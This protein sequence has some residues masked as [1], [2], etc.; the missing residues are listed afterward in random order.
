[1][2]IQIETECT[3]LNV[4]KTEDPPGTVGREIPREP[5]LG[6]NQGGLCWGWMFQTEPGGEREPLR[7]GWGV[8]GGGRGLW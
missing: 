6:W 2:L 5:N 7:G 8:K 4:T 1:M 3:V